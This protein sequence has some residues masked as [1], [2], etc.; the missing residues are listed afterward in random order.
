VRNAHLLAWLDTPAVHHR[1][2]PGA[3]PGWVSWT[4]HARR[5]GA[6]R[7]CASSRRCSSLPG[8]GRRL[9]R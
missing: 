2:C 9:T 7:S 1:S 5:L 3:S 8:P 6:G 4:G